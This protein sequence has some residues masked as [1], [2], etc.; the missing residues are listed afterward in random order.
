MALA[1]AG[2]RA[3]RRRARPRRRASG[4]PRRAFK[5]LGF[6]SLAAVEL[7]NRLG[8]GDRAAAAGDPGLRLP[9]RRR[10]WPATCCAQAA[11]RAG[12]PAQPSRS[13]RRGQRG[14]DRDRRHGLP[15]PR[16][17][18]APPRSSGS[19][20]PRAATRSRAFPDR[21]RLGPRAPLRPRPRAPRHQLR[22]RGRL[23][24]TTPPTSTPTSSA[25]RP[26][27][28]LAMDPQQRL[29]LEALGGAGGR[30]DRPR[31]RCAAAGPAS[32]P[33]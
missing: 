33:A 12:A 11:R 13:A 23:P 30:R 3:G 28:A 27:E 5:D 25:S 18:R 9:D 19:W 22:P 1:D 14:A 2:P 8:A 32:S 26:R 4:R 6:D 15:L 10:R 31:R 21:P 20:S 29:L 17:G 7:R 24:R 16:R